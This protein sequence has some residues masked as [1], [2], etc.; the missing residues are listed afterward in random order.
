MVLGVDAAPDAAAMAAMLAGA[1]EEQD[2]QGFA[3]TGE[4]G[5]GGN[6]DQNQERALAR[7]LFDA[8][9]AD[10]N[11]S[12]DTS[13]VQQFAATIGLK[14]TLQEADEAVREMELAEKK[15]G[16][17]EFDEFWHWFTRKRVGLAPGTV[18]Y[19]MIEA[20]ERAYKAEMG[21]GSP[22]GRMLASKGGGGM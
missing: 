5:T 9:D 18:G 13:E 17:V 6:A 4:A 22:M 3:F 20:R 12:L 21:A 16:V 1:E 8:Y 11:G 15:D 7:S 19:R 14:L 2:F 10:G